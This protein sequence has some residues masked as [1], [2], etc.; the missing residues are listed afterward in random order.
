M[1]LIFLREGHGLNPSPPFPVVSLTG[2]AGLSTQ[3]LTEPKMLH[4][5]VLFIPGLLFASPYRLKTIA[6]GNSVKFQLTALSPPVVF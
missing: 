4:H 3:T 2:R 6:V 5:S 1:G